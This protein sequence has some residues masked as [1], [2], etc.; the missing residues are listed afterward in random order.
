MIDE[1]MVWPS[2]I[3]TAWVIKIEAN[4]FACRHRQFWIGLHCTLSLQGLWKRISW[5]RKEVGKCLTLDRSAGLFWPA[6]KPS[7]IQMPDIGVDFGGRPHLKLTTSSPCNAQP[8]FAEYGL[9]YWALRCQGPANQAPSHTCH[10][11]VSEQALPQIWSVKIFAKDVCSIVLNWQLNLMMSISKQNL[12]LCLRTLI[13]SKVGHQNSA[14]Q[15]FGIIEVS[16]ARF[17]GIVMKSYPFFFE[18]K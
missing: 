17:L 13:S 9:Q 7:S 4:H 18:K 6:P 8:S 3:R 5:P 14:C 12:L 16:E 2:I 10:V 11:V 1:S 15:C